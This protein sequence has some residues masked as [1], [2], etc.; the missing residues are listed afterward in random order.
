MKRSDGEWTR[1]GQLAEQ[2][3]MAAGL[4]HELRQPLMAAKAVLQM[5]QADGDD[6][7]LRE[8]LRHLGHLEAVLEHHAG[9]GRSDERPRLFDF[10]ERTDL[11]L[12]M[13]EHRARQVGV[14]VQWD[15]PSAPV[16]VRGVPASAT[17]VV[18][19]LVR[20]ALDALEGRTAGRLG[21]ALGVQGVFARL[22]VED[23]GPG[24]SQEV[25]QRLGEPFVSTK[26][27]GQGTGLGIHIARRLVES[28][29]GTV[30][31]TG[32]GGGGTVAEVLW[33]LAT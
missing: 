22:A 4:V 32:R 21:V 5:A 1:L 33:P 3:L 6:P 17:Q 26:G 25:V 11:G 19:I 12:A 27:S 30:T 9:L 31:W 29:G 14:R 20:N 28:A 7:T 13:C 18:V 15:A 23:D 24:L 10:A 8:A 2:G 16:Y